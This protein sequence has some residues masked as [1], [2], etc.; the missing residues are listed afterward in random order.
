MA[1]EEQVQGMEAAA[2]NEESQQVLDISW[3]VGFSFL[4][5]FHSFVT[6]NSCV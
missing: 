3:A 2:Y 5:S 6:D 4:L 1:H